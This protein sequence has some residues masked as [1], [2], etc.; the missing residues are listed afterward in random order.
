MVHSDFIVFHF[1]ENS[2]GSKRLAITDIRNFLYSTKSLGTYVL[3]I[4]YVPYEH[5][6]RQALILPRIHLALAIKFA[7]YISHKCKIR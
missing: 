3:S 7:G 5:Y 2:I 6:C 4:V 1:M